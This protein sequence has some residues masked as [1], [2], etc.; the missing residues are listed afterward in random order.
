MKKTLTLTLI[1]F[2]FSAI[3]NAQVTEQWAKRYNGPGNGTDK[4]YSMALDLSGNAYVTGSSISGGFGTEDIATIKYS[5]A[6]TQVWLSRFNGTGSGTDIG[7]AI[8]VDASGN[9]Y[10]TGTSW[11][12]GTSFDYV[13]IKYNSAGDSVWVR[14]YNGSKNANDKAFAIFVDGTGNVYVTGASEGTVGVHGIFED[15]VTVKYSPSGAQLWAASYNGPGG[16]YDGAR[17]I[18]VDGSGN[19]YVTGESGGGSSG[20]GSTYQ[21]YA[22]VK[23]NSIGI[24]QWVSRYNGYLTGNDFAAMLKIDASGNVYV[25]GKSSGSG[26]GYD[27]ATIKYSTAGTQMWVSRYTGAGSN[28]DEGTGIAIDAAGSV[29]VTG[30]CYGGSTNGNDFATIKY[31]SA[32]IQSWVKTYNGPASSNDGGRSIFVDASANV[33]VTGYS[34][35]AGTAFD[36]ATLKYSSTGTQEWLI[37]YTNSNTSG[38]SDDAVC[39]R[40]DG[41]GNVW[42]TGMSALDYATV[43]YAPSVT[44][45]SSNNGSKPI[46]YTL[47]QNYPNPFNPATTIKYHI[48]D[49]THV[50]LTVFDINGKEVANLVN[51]NQEKGIHEINFDAGRLSSGVYFYKLVTNEYSDVKRMTLVK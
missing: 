16:D 51:Q 34:T 29:Y 15:Y 1:L 26:S 47:L 50:S 38:S 4:A 28:S 24:M 5:T 39:V 2:V 10:V 8:A 27:Y 37:R 21:D 49:N 35:G 19:V 9:V 11:S 30:I 43:K 25:T 41:S 23:Y 14:R 32:G 12:T 22:T 17:S 33:F 3:S 31:S 20:S 45:I 36:Y 40:S 18:A 48:P 6:G 46:Q 7:Y 13:T 44:G 42:V